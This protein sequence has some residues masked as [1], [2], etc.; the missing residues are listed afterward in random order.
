MRRD[1]LSLYY[2]KYFLDKETD[3]M[4]KKNKGE[5]GNADK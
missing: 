4:R 1:D 3:K 2:E 5:T